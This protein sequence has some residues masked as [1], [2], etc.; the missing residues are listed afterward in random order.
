MPSW[1]GAARGARAPYNEDFDAGEWRKGWQYHACSAR[2][3]NFSERVVLPSSSSSRRAM[4]LS[5][6]GP[7][8]GRWLTAIPYD[9][10]TT[11]RPLRMQVAL[12]RRLRWPLPLGP[13]RCGG[14]GCRH[15]LDPMGDHWASCMRTGRVRRR[16][17]PLE[18]AWAR[19]F[20]EAGGRVLENVFV[21][22]LGIAGVRPGDARR[23][24][25]VATGLPLARGVPLA[26]D[27][28]MVSVLHCDGSPWA[29]ADQTPGVAL[30]RAENSKNATYPELVASSTALLTTLACEVGGSRRRGS[31]GDRSCAGSAFAFAALGASWVRAAVVG[32][33]VLYA[34]GLPGGHAGR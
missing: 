31:I 29:R 22:D 33:S 26:V 27:A 28:T 13:R 16:A 3:Q 30:G 17:R 25:V 23:L 11:L 34:A 14:T 24:E 20:R 9:P 7:G 1:I 15:E 2:E 32:H 10:A 5:Q 21:R 6:A 12:R 19:I 8:A 4:L 18:R